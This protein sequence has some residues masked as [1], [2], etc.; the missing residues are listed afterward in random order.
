MSRIISEGLKPCPFCS[1]THLKIAFEPNQVWCLN[2][3][4]LNRGP[5]IN[6][7]TMDEAVEAWNTR[8]LATTLDLTGVRRW[9]QW[10][11]KATPCDDGEWVKVSDLATFHNAGQVSGEFT[12]SEMQH[13]GAQC[14]RLID[15]SIK[16][17]Y[18]H[19]MSLRATQPQNSGQVGEYPEIIEICRFK[20]GSMIVLPPESGS[21]ERVEYSRT[22]QPQNSGVA[23]LDRIYRMVSEVVANPADN[24]METFGAIMTEIE[25]LR[26]PHPPTVPQ[27]VHGV[28]SH[29]ELRTAIQ[30]HLE[31][32]WIEAGSASR[33]IASSTAKV[34][35]NL[36]NRQE[37]R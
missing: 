23:L 28:P 32:V 13:F 34:V 12:A 30:D 10:T 6:K 31:K 5:K 1:G 21:I 37:G 16:E 7:A 2:P 11:D 19:F 17:N 33:T 20:D 15:W 24:D 18:Q 8:P 35:E 14:Q 29:Q 9:T 3:E 26:T 27:P 36:L 25:A 4:C 22:T